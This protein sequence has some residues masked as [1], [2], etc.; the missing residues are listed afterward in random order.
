LESDLGAHWNIDPH[1][2]RARRLAERQQRQPY[3]ANLTELSVLQMSAIP[4][5]YFQMRKLPPEKQQKWKNA[6]DREH[7]NLKNLNTY[8]VVQLKDIPKDAQI[9]D[10]TWVYTP[11]DGQNP[12]EKARLC[13]RGDQEKSEA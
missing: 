5:N 7:Q 10:S 6:M 3:V 11:K 2:P 9:L 8:T 4:K 13:V 1:D 12:P